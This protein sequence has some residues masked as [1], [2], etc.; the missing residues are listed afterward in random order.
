MNN[1]TYTTYFVCSKCGA[2]ESPEMARATG[3]LI[4]NDRNSASK[5]VV[6][7]P[8]HI[9]RYALAQTETGRTRVTRHTPVGWNYITAEML[10]LAPVEPL[11]VRQPL[12]LFAAR[13]ADKTFQ[14]L[15]KG[16]YPVIEF[17]FAKVDGEWVMLTPTEI[18]ALVVL[19]TRCDKEDEGG[20][21]WGYYINSFEVMK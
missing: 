10:P 18:L 11:I 5:M 3:W 13:K 2:V 21:Y 8:K 6:R 9:T 20:E 16:G 19:V 4:A 12:R 15:L 14:R 1:F 17:F 7:C